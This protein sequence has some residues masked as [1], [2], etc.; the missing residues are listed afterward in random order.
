MP[1]SAT[2]FERSFGTALRYGIAIEPKGTTPP[3]FRQVHGCAVV[4]VRDADHAA[5]L[6]RAP[7]EADA[8]ITRARGVE[9]SAFS[10]DC[11]P[12]LFFGED[13]GDPIAAVHSGWRGSA[14]GVAAAT[15]ALLDVAPERLHVVMGPCILGCCFAVRDD[16]I[17]GF[18]SYGHPVERW[19]QRGDGGWTFHLD[20]FLWD[21]TLA[22][23]PE[24]NRHREAVRCTVCSEPRLPSFRRD[25]R[26]DPTLRAWIRR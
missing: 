21:T 8:A 1:S 17:E 9:L 12:L 2:V 4:D 18:R 7:P 16:F 11:V 22:T 13:E 24:A 19:L 10:A 3:L 15:M 25:G 23:I 6:R 20:R 26:T 14:Q 5:T